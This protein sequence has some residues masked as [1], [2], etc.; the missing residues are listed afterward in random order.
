[1]HWSLWPLH[2][3]FSCCAKEGTCCSADCL[4]FYIFTIL[5]FIR[6]PNYLILINCF[7]TLQDVPSNALPMDQYFSLAK[8]CSFC[9][10]Q[11]SGGNIC[12]VGLAPK[13]KGGINLAKLSAGCF[14]CCAHKQYW[15]WQCGKTLPSFVEGKQRGTNTL[16][17]ERNFCHQKQIG[18]KICCLD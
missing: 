10:V 12:F 5:V 13:V 2:L 17:Q 14:L 8:T 9:C 18:F 6:F 1:M 3:L 7:Q 15:L 16:K 11:R 4:P